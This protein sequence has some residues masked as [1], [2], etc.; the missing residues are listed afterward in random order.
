M[1]DQVESLARMQVHMEYLQGAVKSLH[2]RLDG[3]A[4]SREVAALKEEVDSLR[5]LVEQQ[6]E[7]MRTL[8]ALERFAK[9][10]AAILAAAS[11]I[12]GLLKII[13]GGG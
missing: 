2:D 11:A 5:D 6:S 12:W 7:M 9:W 1:N 10:V 4:S 8:V 3:M 13:K